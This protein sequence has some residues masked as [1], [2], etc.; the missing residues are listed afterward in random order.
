MKLKRIL[1][2]FLIFASG[3]AL[4]QIVKRLTVLYL[5]PI[6]TVDI[7]EGVFRLRYCEN[8]GAAFSMFEGARWF[9]IILTSVVII[10][11]AFILVTDKA[12]GALARYTLLF[13]ATGGAGNLID[14]ILHGYVV[15]MF[16][17]YLINFAV[18]NI[19]DIFITCS[20]VLFIITFI[21]KK[22]DVIVWK[23]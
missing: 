10:A 9:F 18:F 3:I 23:K 1:I 20:S 15:D 11:I 13:I 21:I 8:T 12:N 4:D 22:V 5:K 17:F 6:G 7:W 2:Y 16:D 14:R 19:A